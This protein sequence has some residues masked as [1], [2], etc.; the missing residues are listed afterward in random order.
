MN[1]MLVEETRRRYVLVVSAYRIAKLM[2]VDV[3]DL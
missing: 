2:V 1:L 3:A